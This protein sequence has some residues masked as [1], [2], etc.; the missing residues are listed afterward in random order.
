MQ[1][2]VFK[3]RPGGVQT[4]VGWIRHHELFGQ[5]LPVRLLVN[6]DAIGAPQEPE[7]LDD[8]LV[9]ATPGGGRYYSN[10]LAPMRYTMNL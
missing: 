4:S 8:K 1:M 10:R 3:T 2:H 7:T 6:K 5:L 9:F